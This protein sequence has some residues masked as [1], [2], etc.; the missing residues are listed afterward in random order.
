MIRHKRNRM[1]RFGL[2]G[3]AIVALLYYTPLLGAILDFIEMRNLSHRIDPLIIPII[4]FFAVI[5]LIGLFR[6]KRS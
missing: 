2:A 6:G 4:S 5:A 3:V 1:L